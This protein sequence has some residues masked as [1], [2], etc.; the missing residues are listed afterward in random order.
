MMFGHAGSIAAG[1]IHMAHNSGLTA[2][3]LTDLLRQAGF[4]GA[5]TRRQDYDLWAI[6]LMPET[7]RN[8]V[9]G[10]LARA[11]VDLSEPNRTS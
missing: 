8:A 3:R 1:H 2:A 7:N 9:I 4:A 11:G 10:K 6:G 5:I